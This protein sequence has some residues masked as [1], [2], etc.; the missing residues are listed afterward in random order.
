MLAHQNAV[1]Y[2]MWTLLVATGLFALITGRWSVAFVSAATMALTFVPIL[3]QNLAGVR[4]PSGFV[5]A[6]IFFIAA[7][8]FMGEAGD[9]YER[10]WWWDVFL[11]SFSAIGFGMIGTV[12]V[13]MMVEAERLEASAFLAAVFAF[14][15]GIAIGAIWEIF[16]FGMDQ[17]FGFNMQKS[18]LVDTMTDLMVDCVGAA[19]G[20]S[21]GFGYL[22]GRQHGLLTG[23]I[24]RFI[25]DNRWMFT[26]RRDQH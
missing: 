2:A 26:R 21:A 9:F 8:L 5:S 15:F 17:L 1:N 12:L 14:S 25:R 11:H 16:E 10:F 24:A 23:S 22:K 3:F 13:L 18:G 4:I 19:L 7:S 20:A 6:I